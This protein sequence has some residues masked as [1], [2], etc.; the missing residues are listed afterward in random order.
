M[1]KDDELVLDVMLD[2]RAQ[3]RYATNVVLVKPAASEKRELEEQHGLPSDS[4]VL[5]SLRGIKNKAQTEAARKVRRELRSKKL[6]Q[7][8]SGEYLMRFHEARGDKVAA[9]SALA[10]RLH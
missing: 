7:R 4:L 1:R 3:K 9:P 2:K 10:P 5:E 8:H 6:S